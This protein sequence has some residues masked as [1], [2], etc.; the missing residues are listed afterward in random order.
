MTNKEIAKSFQNAEDLYHETQ[1]L[2]ENREKFMEIIDQNRSYAQA[3]SEKR[4]DVIINGGLNITWYKK[5]NHG[6]SIAYDEFDKLI[7][8][9]QLQT[10]K[11]LNDSVLSDIIKVKGICQELSYLETW[12]KAFDPKNY[13]QMDTYLQEYNNSPLCEYLS[14]DQSKCADENF[15]EYLDRIQKD[16]DRAIEVLPTLY[17]KLNSTKITLQQRGVM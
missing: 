4:D 15:K 11:R 9:G 13:L 10:Y 14:Y 3:L 12:L 1:S 2:S 6:S 5:L 7:D 17:H 8:S 16:L